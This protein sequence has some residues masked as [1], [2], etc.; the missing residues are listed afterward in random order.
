MLLCD[1]QGGKRNLQVL[2]SPRTPHANVGHLPMTPGMEKATGM[3][4]VRRIGGRN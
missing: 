2:P 1:V 4:P 3:A